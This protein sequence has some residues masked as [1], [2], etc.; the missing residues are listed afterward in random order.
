MK[1][2]EEILRDVRK[3]NDEMGEF[4]VENRAAN[5]DRKLPPVGPAARSLGEAL[6]GLLSNWR[7][8]VHP[9]EYPVPI[10]VRHKIEY[11]ADRKRARLAVETLVDGKTVGI[12][13]VLYGSKEDVEAYE[14]R[15]MSREEVTPG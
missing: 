8:I 1:N 6:R 11:C 4:L 5:V 7:R 15:L 14:R 12:N 3:L 13:T 2:G 9:E 10:E